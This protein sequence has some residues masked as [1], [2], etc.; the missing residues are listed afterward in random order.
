MLDFGPN[1]GMLDCRANGG[2]LDFGAKKGEGLIAVGLV[3]I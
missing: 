2:T 1:G 3:Y